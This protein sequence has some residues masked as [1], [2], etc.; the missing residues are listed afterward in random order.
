MA[1]V[2]VKMVD[3]LI[4]L[5]DFL[6]QHS[7]RH[8]HVLHQETQLQSHTAE[9]TKCDGSH[10]IIRVVSYDY[11]NRY[12]FYVNKIIVLRLALLLLVDLL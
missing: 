9:H 12:V 2:N 6:E 8:G 11:F 5:Q 4:S 3:H 1:S 7:Q 10:Y